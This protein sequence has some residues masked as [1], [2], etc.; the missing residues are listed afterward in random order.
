MS[1]ISPKKSK[2]INFIE[3]LEPELF[4]R[5]F[6]MSMY[7]SGNVMRDFYKWCIDFEPNPRE[8]AISK[9]LVNEIDI[10]LNKITLDNDDIDSIPKFFPLFNKIRVRLYK[11]INI[12]IDRIIFS[13]SFIYLTLY[14]FS[15]KDY[16][17]FLCYIFIGDNS[18]CS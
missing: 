12:K 3:N 8:K 6:L 18:T 5:L 1:N 11:T 2:S 16:I 10:I 7:L 13:D 14:F 4:I 17:V 9:K 15:L